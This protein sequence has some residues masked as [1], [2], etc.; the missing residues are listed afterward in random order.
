MSYL[1][2]TQQD[3][4]EVIGE[5][6]LQVAKRVGVSTN[7][8]ETSWSLVHLEGIQKILLDEI[9]E[10]DLVAARTLSLYVDS[11]REWYEASCRFT[12]GDATKQEVQSLMEKRG[13]MRQAL[14]NYLMA[15]FPLS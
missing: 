13:L 14:T 10:I 4:N 6:F 3:C 15:Q 7:L 8:T 2:M 12:K 9:Q 1:D 11:Y 5:A